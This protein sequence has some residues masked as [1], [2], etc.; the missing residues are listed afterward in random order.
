[1]IHVTL[2]SREGSW[3]ESP[4]LPFLDSYPRQILSLLATLLHVTLLCRGA[5][6]IISCASL[7]L[8]WTDSLFGLKRLHSFPPEHTG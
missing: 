3:G 6:N 4:T 7:L 8:I 1:M 5:T 2:F